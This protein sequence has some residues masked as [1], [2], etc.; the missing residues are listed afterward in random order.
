MPLVMSRLARMRAA[1]TSQPLH[2]QLGLL[3]RTR[4]QQEDF[5]QRDPFDLP[6][7][8]GALVV[9]DRGFEQRG[10]VLAH[11]RDGRVDVEAG[12]RVALLRHGARRAAPLVERLVDL[13]HFGLHQQLH[14]HGDL[15]ERAGDEPE[16]AADLADAV[17]HGVPGDLGL[18]EAEL[19]HQLRLH[20]RGRRRRARRACRPRRRT[21]RPAR[22]GAAARA[23]RGGAAS[24]RA[25]RRS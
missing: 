23:V 22:A 12:D 3:Q 20:L 25:A 17:A 1:S 18:A 7:P 6:R 24:P 13:G 19:L 9:G 16:E 21:R 8:G 4:R 10:D 11:Q 15:A 5:R 2:Q 14:V